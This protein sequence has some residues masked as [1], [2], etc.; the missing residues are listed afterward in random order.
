MDITGLGDETVGQLLETGLVKDLSDLYHLTPIDRAGLEG[1]AEKSIENLMQA[2]ESS[3]R[4]RLDR[5]LYALG[6]EHV[7]GT[8]ARLLADHYQALDPMLDA[9]EEALQEIHGIGPEVAQAVRRFFSNPRNRKVL[10][11]LKEAGVRPVAERKP[12]GPQPLA[13]QVVVFT[14]T[15]ERMTRPEAAKRAED[16]GAR[17]ASGIGKQVTLVVAGPGAG[18]KLDEAR[19]KKIPVIDEAAF[20]ARIGAD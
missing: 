11:R 2:I 3:K 4:P 19:K 8:I 13:G 14:G 15:L 20:L 10:E 9:G 17:V 5:F 18:A 16:A 12:K 6:I 1:F 7:G